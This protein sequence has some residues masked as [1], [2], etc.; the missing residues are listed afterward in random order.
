VVEGGTDD[1]IA[2]TILDYKTPG[3]QTY[4]TTSVAL[5]DEKGVPITINFF[6]PNIAQIGVLVTI[7]TLTSW[8]ESNETI[9][10]NAISAYIASIPIGG[11]IVLTQLY[12]IAYVP[13]TTAAGSFNIESIELSEQAIGSIHLT[14]NPAGS[15]TVTV[16]GLLITFVASS[17]SGNEVLIGASAI[18]TAAALQAFL[19]ASMSSDLIPAT[20]SIDGTTSAQV[21]ITYITPG[22]TGDTFTLA[23]SSTA[24]TLSGGTL[25]GGGFGSSDIDLAFNVLAVCAAGNVSFIT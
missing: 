16:N 8:I 15:D 3:T 24:I 11:I 18:A 21:D 14:S 23:K 2:N 20:Y 10:A 12:A 9:I 1:D 6:R 13:G 25:T 5:T 17:P 4:G 19:A 7:S 22:P